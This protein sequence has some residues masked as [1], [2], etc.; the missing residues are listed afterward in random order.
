MLPDKYESGTMNL[1]GIAGLNA[2]L[3]Y[4]EETGIEVIAKKKTELTRMFLEG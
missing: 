3:I 4:L 2:A 1:P